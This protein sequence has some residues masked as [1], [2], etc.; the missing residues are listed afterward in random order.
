MALFDILACHFFIL[1]G[2]YPVSHLI[3][4]QLVSC[5]ESRPGSPKLFYLGLGSLGLS[6]TKKA[7]PHF[8]NSAGDW[9]KKKEEAIPSQSMPP[10][11]RNS[12]GTNVPPTASEP[13]GEN[14]VASR[15]GGGIPL[16]ENEVISEQRHARQEPDLMARMTAMLKDLEQEVH[17]LK[18]DRTQEIREIGR[19]HV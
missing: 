10:K 17:L 13:V 3:L 19:A 11:Q 1:S 14:E 8:G 9:A 7:L 4:K 5:G 6:V 2:A 12:K 16:V 18:E 15:Q